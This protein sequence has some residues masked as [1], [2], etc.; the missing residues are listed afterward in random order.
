M[1]RE[2]A[3]RMITLT[4]GEDLSSAQYLIMQLSDENTVTKAT[5]SNQTLIGVLQNDPESGEPAAV[6]FS[7]VSKVIAGGAISAG[8]YVTADANGKAVASS[9]AIYDERTIGIAL[10]DASGADEVIPVLLTIGS[11][12]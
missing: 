2:E 3:L 8:D 11:L 4:A 10:E 12:G 5:A 1:A 9:G 6:A 7:G